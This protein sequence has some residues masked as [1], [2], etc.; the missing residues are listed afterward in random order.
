MVFLLLC[1]G[2]AKTCLRQ[3]KEK[4]ELAAF[5]FLYV[6]STGFIGVAILL[7]G[8]AG[9]NPPVSTVLHNGLRGCYSP[10]QTYIGN[11]CYLEGALIVIKTKGG[12]SLS[13]AAD[14]PL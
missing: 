2:E 10:Q 14:R 9:A 6:Y 5:V 7:V 8:F 13:K 4:D 1:C 3:A 11:S 12:W